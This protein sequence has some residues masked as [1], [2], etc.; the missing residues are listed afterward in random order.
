MC[1]YETAKD[2]SSAIT[3]FQ[4]LFCISTFYFVIL[5]CLCLYETAKDELQQQKSQQCNYCSLSALPGLFI[6]CLRFSQAYLELPP[7]SFSILSVPYFFLPYFQPYFLYLTQLVVFLT[8]LPRT[9]TSIQHY[10][11]TILSSI[12]SL[13]Y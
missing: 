6:A 1:L 11:F 12:L 2:R 8:C 5:F 3:V 4:F 7:A 13:S 10:T 9:T